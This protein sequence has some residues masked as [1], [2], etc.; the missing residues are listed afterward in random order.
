MGTLGGIAGAAMGNPAAMTSLTGLSGGGGSQGDA[1]GA[2]FTGMAPG[3]NA[4]G[5]GPGGEDYSQGI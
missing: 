5:F 2:V 1:S 4:Q 3:T